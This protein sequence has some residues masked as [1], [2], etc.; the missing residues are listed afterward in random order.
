[1]ARNVET[2]I[3]ELIP[4]SVIIGRLKTRNSREGVNEIRREI[5]LVHSCE[6]QHVVGR[7]GCPIVAGNQI[8]RMTFG[9]YQRH[10]PLVA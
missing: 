10:E 3:F 8:A 6:S 2:N 4:E 9:Q 7:F 1:M 5:A